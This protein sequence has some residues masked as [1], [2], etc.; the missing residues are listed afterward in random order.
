[1]RRGGGRLVDGGEGVRYADRC[2][3]ALPTIPVPGPACSA[4]PVPTQPC[5]VCPRLAHEFASWRET[6][7][8]R[9]MH[10]R[11]VRREQSLRQENQTLRARIRDREGRLFGRRID[12][13]AV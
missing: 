4:P 2:M 3:E 1:M 5:P 7:F 10:R 6:A 8:W 11:A 9:A 13:V 12:A